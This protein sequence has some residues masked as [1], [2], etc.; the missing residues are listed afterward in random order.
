MRASVTRDSLGGQEQKGAS[1]EKLASDL[2]L[3]VKTRKE[4]GSWRQVYGS[5]FGF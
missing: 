5:R 2:V 3:R 4:S 1:P